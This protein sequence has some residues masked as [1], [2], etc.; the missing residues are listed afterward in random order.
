MRTLKT[1]SILLTAEREV[2]IREIDIP[3]IKDDQILIESVANGICM[4]EIFTVYPALRNSDI[5]GLSVMKALGG[6]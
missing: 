2:E 3:E 1:E 6:R 5:P 4:F